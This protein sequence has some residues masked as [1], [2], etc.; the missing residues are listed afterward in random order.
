MKSLGRQGGLK[1]AKCK[2]KN[3]NCHVRNVASTWLFRV[4]PANGIL[5]ARNLHFAFYILQFAFSAASAGFMVP[6]VLP[7]AKD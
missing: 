2:L 5:A 3:A 7:A 6:V 4:D 1:N